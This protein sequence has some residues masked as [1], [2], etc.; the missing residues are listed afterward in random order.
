MIHGGISKNGDEYVTWYFERR[1]VVL[2]REWCGTL[3]RV[4]WDFEEVS[5]LI[6]RGWKAYFKKVKLWKAN[7]ERVL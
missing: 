4:V 3:K 1:V 5:V 6:L 7:L 2:W